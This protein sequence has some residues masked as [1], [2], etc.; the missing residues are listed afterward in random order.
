MTSLPSNFPQAGGRRL[1][2]C[3]SKDDS[4]GLEHRPLFRLVDHHN[5][6][7]AISLT[8]SPNS[9]KSLKEVLKIILA[10]D[11]ASF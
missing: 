4:S 5:K 2:S 9:E 7:W 8:A 3:S 6:S 1:E 11:Y 10:M